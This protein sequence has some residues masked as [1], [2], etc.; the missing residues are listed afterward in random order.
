MEDEQNNDWDFR[1]IYIAILVWLMRQLRKQ[2][3]PSA[4]ATLL[5]FMLQH[6]LRVWEL[7]LFHVKF[8]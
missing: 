2:T 8:K 1:E 6:G 3:S 5:W 4:P 7:D